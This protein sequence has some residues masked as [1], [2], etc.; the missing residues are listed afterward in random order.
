M[1]QGKEVAFVTTAQL[2]KAEEVF[3]WDREKYA[4]KFVLRAVMV[5][6]RDRKEDPAK[7][8]M[9]VNR[10]FQSGQEIRSSTLIRIDSEN[11][12]YESKNTIY[13]VVPEDQVEVYQMCVPTT[14]NP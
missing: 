10:T 1:S 3:T 6:D 11:N 5:A 2:V 14:N 4:G 9:P 12:E 8:V 7:V 13:K